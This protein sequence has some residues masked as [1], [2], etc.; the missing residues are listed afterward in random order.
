MESFPFPLESVPGIIIEVEGEALGKEKKRI[1]IVGL[2]KDT[3]EIT[4]EF[5]IEANEGEG[6]QAS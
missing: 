4:H 1:D 2:V 3:R 5:G 6:Q